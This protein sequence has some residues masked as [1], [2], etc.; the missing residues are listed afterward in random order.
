ML[1]G[2]TLLTGAP[3]GAELGV[4][5][6]ATLLVRLRRG[7]EL[8]VPNGAPLLVRLPRGAELVLLLGAPLLVRLPLRA[9]GHLITLLLGTSLHGTEGGKPVELVT[10]Y[11][12]GAELGLPDGAILLVRLRRGAELGVSNGATLLP[13]SPPPPSPPA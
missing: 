9:T 3:R 6:G 5:N 11:L 2:A 12:G 7:A 8:G 4:P 10:T 13:S 1:L